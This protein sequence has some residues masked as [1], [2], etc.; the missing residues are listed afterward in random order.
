[1]SEYQADAPHH[2]FPIKET[3]KS[4][5][6]EGTEQERTGSSDSLSSSSPA[7][8][9]LHP[10]DTPTASCAVC[11]CLVILHVS[12][13]LDEAMSTAPQIQDPLLTAHLL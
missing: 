11:L 7:A 5:P 4:S 13:E 8:E 2:E 6:L 12:I 10:F 3:T 9:R 1:M